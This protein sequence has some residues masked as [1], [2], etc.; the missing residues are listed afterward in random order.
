MATDD[1]GEFRIRAPT[2]IAKID[3][4]IVLVRE[5]LSPQDQAESNL[6]CA[7][8]TAFARDAAAKLG[9]LQGDRHQGGLSLDEG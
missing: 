8:Q 3:M 9:N 4:G 6:F 7:C 1:I 2:P 5:R